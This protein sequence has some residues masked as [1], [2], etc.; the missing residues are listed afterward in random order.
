MD[1]C[2]ISWQITCVYLICVKVPMWVLIV[3]PEL[4]MFLV[5][6]RVK[7]GLEHLHSA[8]NMRSDLKIIFGWTTVTVNLT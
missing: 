6:A 1:L 5:D 2:A 7:Q 3:D 4:Q 8:H